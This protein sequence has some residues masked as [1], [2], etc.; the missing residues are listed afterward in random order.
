[1]CIFP[2][3]QKIKVDLKL[4]RDETKLTLASHAKKREAEIKV[5]KQIASA[6][7]F[8]SSLSFVH[9]ESY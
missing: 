7:F 6:T 9:L 2:L 1:M 8:K 5:V 3:G 4:L